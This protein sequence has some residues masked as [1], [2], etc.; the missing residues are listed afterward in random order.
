MTS[1]LA[2]P[3]SPSGPVQQRSTDFTADDE[4]NVLSI[5]FGVLGTVIALLSFAIGYRQLVAARRSGSNSSPAELGMRH[6][7][8][9]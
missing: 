7:I 9:G 8:G 2:L 3:A 1:K 6:Y 5:V 4:G